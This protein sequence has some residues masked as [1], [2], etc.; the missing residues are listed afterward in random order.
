M[1]TLNNILK[2][3]LLLV[4]M[5]FTFSNSYT[6]R[7]LEWQLSEGVTICESPVKLTYTLQ[8]RTDNSSSSPALASS[9]LRFFYDAKNLKNLRI[10][11]IY[12]G[13]SISG[14]TQSNPVL[15]E[16]LGFENKEGVFVQFDLIHSRS[17]PP[18]KLN[19]MPLNVLEISFDID[20]AA[21]YPLKI[22]IV[23]DNNHATSGQGREKDDGYIP[24]NGGIAGNY[25]LNKNLNTV[26][27]ADD[28]V[29][30]TSWKPNPNFKGKIIQDR[31]VP[32]KFVAG[33]KIFNPCIGNSKS[34]EEELTK[35]DDN[36]TV[37]L[38]DSVFAYPV[39]YEDYVFVHYSFPYDTDVLIQII[40][41]RG[42]L[43]EELIERNYKA[44]VEVETQ[45]DLSRVSQQ[46]LFLKVT[47]HQTS[48]V[49]KIV[50]SKSQY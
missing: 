20:D 30:Y 23:L 2:Q 27:D 17:M 37:Y 21:K 9:T 5:C 8:V 44:D 43:I 38:S 16:I 50:A 48:V 36:T 7:V 24:G 33:Q 45:L 47:T 32:G 34:T 49:K 26:I 15:G 14:I 11:N 39:P 1:N 29:I 25:Y 10:E 41:I 22:P 12:P 42:A 19:M 4:V 46:M 35:Q 18:M 31:L 3:G 6:Q 40:D 13:Y 28:E